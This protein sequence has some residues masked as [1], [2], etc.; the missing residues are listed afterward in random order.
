MQ[1]FAMA[2]YPLT[3][4]RVSLSAS[5]MA[6]DWCTPWTFLLIFMHWTGTTTV[7]SSWQSRLWKSWR[8]SWMA[9][10]DSWCQMTT[11]SLASSQAEANKCNL[12]CQA[13]AREVSSC[14]QET[15]HDFCRPGKGVWWECLRRS[16]GARRENL[17][18]WSGLCDWCRGC[19]LMCGAVSMLVIG[20]VMSLMWK[21]FT[22]ALYLAHCFSSFGLKPYQASSTLGSPRMTS[23]LMALLSSLNR[24]RNVLGGS[25]LGKKQ[26]RRK[27]W[28]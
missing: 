10:S 1:S 23:M 6:C 17:V 12:C 27:G 7:I 24:S 4:S 8:G 13:A 19:M 11:P 18:W 26:W 20:T 25:W 16:S 28:E 9:S 3:E 15:L 2:R 5:T 22:K 14:Q 21:L